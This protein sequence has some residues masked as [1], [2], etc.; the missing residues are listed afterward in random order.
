MSIP[1]HGSAPHLVGHTLEDVRQ[2]SFAED[3]V[4]IQ[5]ACWLYLK[6]QGAWFRL[7]LDWG[8]V[9]WY[10]EELEPKTWS[11]PNKGWTYPVRELEGARAF[12]G[13]L[14]SSLVYTGGGDTARVT[15]CFENGKNLIF[16]GTGDVNECLAV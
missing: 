13:S 4:P 15:I 16:T 12:I 7:V 9:H 10:S 5:G 1:V 14:V 2:G 8:T 3:G 6:S 11:I